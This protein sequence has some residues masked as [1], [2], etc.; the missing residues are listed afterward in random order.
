MFVLCIVFKLSFP[1]KATMPFQADFS[2][3]CFFEQIRQAEDAVAKKKSN[4]TYLEITVN[5]SEIQ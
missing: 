1:D 5:K 3:G 4:P 2:P